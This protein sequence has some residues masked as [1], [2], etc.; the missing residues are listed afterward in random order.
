MN[1]PTKTG[2]VSSEVGTIKHHFAKAT[3]L[4]LYDLYQRSYSL[5]LEKK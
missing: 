3:L 1:D 4:Y 2:I 5:W